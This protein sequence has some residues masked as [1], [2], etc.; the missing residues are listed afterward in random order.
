MI[1]VQLKYFICFV[2]M[3]FDVIWF[4]SIWISPT[5]TK[6]KITANGSPSGLIN[7][8]WAGQVSSC[9]RVWKILTITHAG[10]PVARQLS[11]LFFV[12]YTNPL[13]VCHWSGPATKIRIFQINNM[14]PKKI[15][16]CI[17]KDLSID[18][19]SMPWKRNET[20]YKKPGRTS[21][22][23]FKALAKNKSTKK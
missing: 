7:S 4:N 17:Y 3:K 2:F 19:L 10:V 20:K 16:K 23:R 13:T 22:R 8:A 18:P 9:Y 12:L 14:Q 1:S 15:Q 6:W 11:F 21:S 5:S